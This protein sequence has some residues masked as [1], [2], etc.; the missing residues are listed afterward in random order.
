MM[1]NGSRS[2]AV[3]LSVAVAIAVTFMVISALRSSTTSAS[4]ML[5][6]GETHAD[7]RGDGDSNDGAVERE[8]SAAQASIAGTLW[9]ETADEAARRSAGCLDC[10]NGIEDMHNG[11]INLGCTDCHGGDANIRS[12]P[13]AAK[14]SAAY[15]EAESK[16]HVHPL[17]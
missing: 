8:K 13:G 4:A 16:A 6:G 2:R 14:G 5:A 7:R 12:A 15:S 17:H 10:H 9:G 11:A 1:V 3:K